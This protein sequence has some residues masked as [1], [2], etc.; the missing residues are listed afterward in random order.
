MQSKLLHIKKTDRLLGVSKAFLER[1]RLAG[2]QIPPMDSIG[3]E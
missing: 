1:D 3:M 2:A